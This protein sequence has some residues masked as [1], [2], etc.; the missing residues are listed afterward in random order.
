MFYHKPRF[1]VLDEA[2]SAVSNDVEALMYHSA[3]D[4]G[5]TLITISHRPTLFKYHPYLLR[6]GEGRD[7]KQWEFSQI[8]TSQS[9]AQSVEAEMRRL[10]RA[11]GEMDGL[12]ERLDAINGEL[13][14]NYGSAKEAGNAKRTLI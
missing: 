5:I 9:L 7:G 1:A 6:I 8:G 14:L 12:R 4:A 10:T 11:L 2:T 13:G 3:K